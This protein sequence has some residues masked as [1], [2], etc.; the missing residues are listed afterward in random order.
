M[1]TG[2]SVMS[3][4]DQLDSVAAIDRLVDEVYGVDLAAVSPRVLHVTSAWLR[5]DELVTIRINDH[6]PKSAFDFFVLNLCRTRADAIV[7]T[8]QILRDEPEMHH[9]LQGPGRVPELLEAWRRERLGKTSPPASLVLSSGRD[10]DLEH[11]VFRGP[12]RAIV[13]TSPEGE[14]RLAERP[15]RDAVEVVAVDDPGPR[16]AVEVL[17]ERFGAET[18]GIEAGPSTA[19][20]LY[21]PPVVVDELLLSIYRGELDERARGKR[22]LGVGEVEAKLD[23][24]PTSRPEGEPDW[25]FERFT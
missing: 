23:R 24:W 19:G 5:G 10:L 11:P 8:G 20:K 2:G 22:F 1:R 13:L 9:G 25:S 15:G 7:T 21:E 6:A 18:V 16:R 14:E 4:L 12:G 3:R 17:R